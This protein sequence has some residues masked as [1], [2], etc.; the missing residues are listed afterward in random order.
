MSEAIDDYI[1]NLKAKLSFVITSQRGLGMSWAEKQVILQSLLEASNDFASISIVDAKGNELLTFADTFNLMTAKLREYNDIQ[2]DRLIAE[3]TKT[4]A[5]IYSISDGLIMTDF[6]GRIMLLNKPA[7]EMMNIKETNIE[8]KFIFDYIKDES[9][10][11]SLKE[12]TEKRNET[13]IK[14]LDFS[15]EAAGRIIKSKTDAVVTEKG[16]DLGVVTVLHDIT[17]EKEIEKTKEDFISLITH[18]L[19]SPITSIRGFP[20]KEK[21]FQERRVS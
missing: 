5:V 20:G 11:A 19:Q 10:L 16:K 12:I 7:R 17:L 1:I 6:S 18:D 15:H 9:I 14:E 3:R 8:D 4:S 2:I 21:K 13:L